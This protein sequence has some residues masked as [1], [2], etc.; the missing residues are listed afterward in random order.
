MLLNSCILL[1]LIIGAV[2]SVLSQDLNDF[3]HI[4]KHERFL[5]EGEVLIA[6]TDASGK[7][8]IDLFDQLLLKGGCNLNLEQAEPPAASPPPAAKWADWP[9]A[10][11]ACAKISNLYD[12]QKRIKCEL[13]ALTA[14]AGNEG[15]LLTLSRKEIDFIKENA[16]KLSGS[17]YYVWSEA[18]HPAVALAQYATAMYAA[19]TR[20]ATNYCEVGSHKGTSMAF[21]IDVLKKWGADGGKYYSIDPYYSDK[22]Q[23]YSQVD[24]ATELIHSEASKVKK[25]IKG[26]CGNELNA[27]NTACKTIEAETAVSGSFMAAAFALYELIGQEGKVKL[28]RSFSNVGLVKL[29]HFISHGHAELI[30]VLY[31]DGEHEGKTPI[32][33]LMLAL[34]VVRANG[35]IILD[36]WFGKDVHSL[37]LKMDK[38][39]PKVFESWKTASYKI[40][41]PGSRTRR[42]KE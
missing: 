34:T 30:D 12:T 2:T 6:T 17:S 13:D 26:L 15:D 42:I 23:T 8:L 33:D 4:R 20:N 10:V 36:D 32:Y 1:V 38:C 18:L 3:S 28:F 11:K 31:I 16:V 25:M 37:K 21:F 29:N 22:L 7:A 14:S 24:S 9:Y 5:S 27:T 19:N 40:T 35:I 39:F 41:V